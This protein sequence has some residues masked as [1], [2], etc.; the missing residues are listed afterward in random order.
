MVPLDR[1]CPNYEF[2]TS[3]YQLVID[4]ILLDMPNF[5]IYLGMD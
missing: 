3:D 1:V 4:H 5:D 2:T